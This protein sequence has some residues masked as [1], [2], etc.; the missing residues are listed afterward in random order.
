MKICKD[1]WQSMRDAIEARGMFGL[2]QKSGEAALEN[3]MKA[4]EGPAR[5]SLIR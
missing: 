2:V 5:R 3:E 4:L 1:H